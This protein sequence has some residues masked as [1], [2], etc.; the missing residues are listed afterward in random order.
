[1]NARASRLLIGAGLVTWIVAGVHGWAPNGPARLPWLGAFF[2]F[3]VAFL[4]NARS[5][6]EPLPRWQCLALLAVQSVMALVMDTIAPSGF[7]GA[8]L[9]VVAGELAFRMG[10]V[11]AAAWTLG[12]SALFFGLVTRHAPVAGAALA[13]LA[14][15]ALQLFAVAA[16][17]LAVREREQ[18]EEL[19][20][21]NAELVATER[22][23]EVATR[24]G[25]RLRIARELHDS[26][27][28][29]LVALS[30]QLEVATHVADGE[31]RQPVAQA[32]A[33]ARLLFADVRDA[34]GELREERAPQLSTAL[35]ALVLG[36]A[37]PR[38]HLAIAATVEPLPPA[39][40]H[41]LFRCVQETVTNAVRHAAARNVWIDIQRHDDRV[42]LRARDDGRGASGVTPGH[43]LDG[44]RERIE[45]AGGRLELSARPGTGFAVRAVFPTNGNPERAS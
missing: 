44:M 22:L 32:R 30:L 27:G 21:V 31:A 10:T 36:I 41:A 3:G 37:A 19:A 28:H 40:A 24:N 38:I 43:G 12:Q 2:A 18:R 39:Q 7:D 4:V 35:E 42:E 8:L 17:H 45:G 25:E 6:R 13:T 16:G 11:S 20:R 15:V 29:H 9:V 34:V 26:L 5:L 33:I 23:L 14:F 1:L